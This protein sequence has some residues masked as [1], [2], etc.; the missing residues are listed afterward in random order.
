MVGPLF[1]ISAINVARAATHKA[2]RALGLS[3]PVELSVDSHDPSH[4][5]RLFIRI[6]G[7]DQRT[8]EVAVDDTAILACIS[9]VTDVDALVND[10]ATKVAEAAREVLA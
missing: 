7:P 9:G 5:L 4:V 8:R 3:T 2:D 1:T 6:S 10:L